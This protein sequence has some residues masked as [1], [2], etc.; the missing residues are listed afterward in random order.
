MDQDETARN[1]AKDNLESYSYSLREYIH[2]LETAVN[3]TLHW[4][5]DSQEAS[6]DEYEERR[7][8][9]EALHYAQI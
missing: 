6:K 8:E 5:D 9:L 7:K 2:K 3:E 1:I 4:L